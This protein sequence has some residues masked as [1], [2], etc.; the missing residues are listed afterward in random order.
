MMAVAIAQSEV[1]ARMGL[2][3][4]AAAMLC[5]LLVA[6]CAATSDESQVRKA[7]APTGKLRVGLISVPVHAVRDPYSG[8]LRGVSHD[9]GRELAARL[10]VGFEP[11]VYRNPN[12]YLTAGL[13]GGWDVGSLGLEPQRQALFDFA[14]P[15]LVV[16]Y[17]Y[18][19]SAEVR[20]ASISDVDRSGVRVALVE[21]SASRP[22]HGRKLA[23][24]I[25][26]IENVR[27]TPF[28]HFP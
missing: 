12:E 10:G 20:I 14:P 18:L 27:F 4:H 6:A 2:I 24:A 9:L 1:R 21:K 19:V 23:F 8:N 22:G 15:H 7:L 16:D 3:R 11:I 28:E 5:A 26:E 25:I 17:G 13:A